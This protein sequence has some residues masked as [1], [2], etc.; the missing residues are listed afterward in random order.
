MTSRESAASPERMTPRERLQGVIL[1][2]HMRAA[3][4]T[5][6]SFGLEY[7]A[8]QGPAETDQERAIATSDFVVGH[9]DF[10]PNTS[11]KPVHAGRILGYSFFTLLDSTT[12]SDYMARVVGED[13]RAYSRESVAAPVKRLRVQLMKSA[14]DRGSRDQGLIFVA[15]GMSPAAVH[16]DDVDYAVK[17]SH[18]QYDDY[19]L[20]SLD[21]VA[22]L[23]SDEAIDKLSDDICSVIMNAI[24]ASDVQTSVV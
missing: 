13:N 2:A 3:V 12:P 20:A 21:K 9:I 4:E 16:I 14:E 22:D 10:D 23:F 19:N 11:P 1:D 17:G 6:R 5:Y 7:E 18:N 8:Q 15:P 24:E